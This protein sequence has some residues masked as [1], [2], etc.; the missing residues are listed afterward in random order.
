M[1]ESC[2]PMQLE[3]LSATLSCS[4]TS[5]KRRAV[6]FSIDKLRTARALLYLSSAG[7]NG[8]IYS[9]PNKRRVLFAHRGAGRGLCT[10][11]LK[12]LG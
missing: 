4:Q 12:T 6:P 11:N 10:G 7:Y 2:L 1:K 8:G 3:W 9:A 5:T